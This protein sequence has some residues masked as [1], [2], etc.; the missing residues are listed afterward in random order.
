VPKG[1]QGDRENRGDL[2]PLPGGHHGLSRQQVVESQRERLL[3]AVATLIAERGYAATPIT[4]IAKAASVANRVFYANF[5]DKETAFLAAFDAVAD[6]LRGLIAAAAAEAGDD[7]SE[8]EIVAFRTILEFF[9]AEPELARLCLV[10][11]FTATPAIGAHFREVIASAVP[12]LAEGR[13]F[14]DAGDDLPAS[15]EDS[16]LGGIVS[17]LSRSLLTDAGPLIDR[18]PDLIEFALAPY[19]GADRARELAAEASSQNQA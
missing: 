10:V 13:K 15:T 8:R 6:H 12:Y 14:S 18:L 2:G 16:L 3:A 4:E 17:Q 1:D 11:P 7:W 9:D 19:L 5:D